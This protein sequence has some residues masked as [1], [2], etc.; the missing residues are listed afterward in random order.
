MSIKNSKPIEKVVKVSLEDFSNIEPRIIATGKF[1]LAEC[2]NKATENDAKSVYED[3]NLS[4][5]LGLM[6]IRIA[7]KKMELRQKVNMALS[8]PPMP[9]KVNMGEQWINGK[10]MYAGMEFDSSYDHEAFVMYDVKED[11]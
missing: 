8:K 3:I 9:V 2:I 7:P 1:S 5:G 4:Q 6:R 10:F 11:Q